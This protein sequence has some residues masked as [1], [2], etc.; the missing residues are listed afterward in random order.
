MPTVIVVTTDATKAAAQ[1]AIVTHLL[2]A[3]GVW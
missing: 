3:P 1:S 2:I